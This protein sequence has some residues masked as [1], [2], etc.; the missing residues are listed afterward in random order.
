[1]VPGWGT[2]I[3]KLL[4]TGQ[5]E[6]EREREREYGTGTKEKKRTQRLMTQNTESRN[7]STH[8]WSIN[9]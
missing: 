7:K 5:K 8:L 3:C 6:R 2:K 1:M 9:L 4:G